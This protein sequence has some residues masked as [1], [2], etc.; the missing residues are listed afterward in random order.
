MRKWGKK[1]GLDRGWGMAY[2]PPP[3]GTFPES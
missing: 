1:P 3:S 2:I